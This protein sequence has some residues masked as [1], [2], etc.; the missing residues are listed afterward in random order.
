MTCP[1]CQENLTTKEVRVKDGTP[2]DIEYCPYCGGYWL[3]HWEVNFIPLKNIKKLIKKVPKVPDPNLIDRVMK[4]P[5]CHKK[6]DLLRGENVPLNLT[7][8][9]CPECRGN[10]FPK[11]QLL[12]FK[13]AQ[14][15]KLA[16]IKIW[17]IPLGSVFSILLPVLIIFLITVSIPLTVYLSQKKQKQRIEAQG[18]IN[19]F[20][21]YFINETTVLIALN[22]T[23]EMMV[24]LEYGT[25]WRSLQKVPVSTTFEIFHKITLRN[26]K[27][28]TSYLYRLILK[29]KRGRSISLPLSDFQ[30]K[31]NY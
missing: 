3:D 6:L 27:P 28:K 26:L 9:F 14:E 16:Y 21:I 23:N 17:Q 11:G 13:K 5:H 25:N 2:I 1:Y 20:R 30:T 31:D 4:C 8:F 19:N 10:W 22:T 7:V 18:L 24:D 29:D 15:A 12:T